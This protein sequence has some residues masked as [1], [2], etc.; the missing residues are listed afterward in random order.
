MS[1]SKCQCPC[2]TKRDARFLMFRHGAMAFPLDGSTDLRT[3]LFHQA[4]KQTE[5]LVLQQLGDL[6]KRGLLVI[7]QTEPVLTEH[8]LPGG[9]WEF[10]M[11][12]AVRLNLRDREVIETLEAENKRLREQLR[13][14]DDALT[15]FRGKESEL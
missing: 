2:C 8:Q 7:E 13:T 12:K 9:D 14:I 10:T 6:V 1:V 4:E 3:K 5:E 11:E 15:A